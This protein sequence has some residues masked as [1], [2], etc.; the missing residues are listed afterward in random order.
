MSLLSNREDVSMKTVKLGLG[1]M[2]RGPSSCRE[3]YDFIEDLGEDVVIE[4]VPASSEDTLKFNKCPCLK[5]SIMK[6]NY[7]ALIDSGSQITCISEVVY[8]S[9][10]SIGMIRELPVS[11]V[12]VMS[13]IGRKTTTVRNRYF[14]VWK[15]VKLSWN[16][17]FW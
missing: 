7:S 4:D 8:R 13:A 2:C 15:L 12:L 1:A 10:L 9:L 14:Y 3:F 11:N 16:M 5:V 6:K 17:Y